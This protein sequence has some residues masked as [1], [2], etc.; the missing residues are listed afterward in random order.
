MWH[1][2]EEVKSIQACGGETVASRSLVRSRR[3][4][5]ENIKMDLKEINMNGL[6]SSSSG[7]G[8]VASCCEHGNE[9]S[10]YI[11]CKDFLE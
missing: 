11:K 8:Q 2:R 10:G 6:D 1:V 5:E 3:R 4:W 9:L 7:W